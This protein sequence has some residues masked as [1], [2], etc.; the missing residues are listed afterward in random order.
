MGGTLPS[1]M[2]EIA[3]KGDWVPVYTIYMASTLLLLQSFQK[4]H[5]KASLRKL[6]EQPEGTQI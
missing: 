5:Q 3:A 2:G 4:H 1:G 6:M